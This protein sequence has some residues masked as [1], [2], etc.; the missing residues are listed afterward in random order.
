MA[1]EKMTIPLDREKVALDAL[2]RR[3]QLRNDIA[4]YRA[5]PQ[6]AAEMLIADVDA[7]D[8]DDH[9]DWKALYPD[10]SA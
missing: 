8:L 6:T 4:A 1:R 2:I 9:V 3:E 5:L 7:V 10:V